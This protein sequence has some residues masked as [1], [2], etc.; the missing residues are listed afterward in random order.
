MTA[1]AISTRCACPTLM[2][3]GYLR[4]N[5][6]LEGKL[7]LSSAARMARSQSA[8][9]PEACARQASLNWVRIF[10]A[11]FRDD[12]GLCSTSA[13]FLPRRSRSSRSRRVNRS[14]PSKWIVPSVCARLPIEQA[15]NRHGQGALAR[16]ALA[17]QSEHFALANI[18]VH[19]AQ[20]GR[21]SAIAHGNAARREERRIGC[22]GS[23]L[24]ASVFLCFFK[25]VKSAQVRG[26]EVDSTSPKAAPTFQYVCGTRITGLAPCTARQPPTEHS[27]SPDK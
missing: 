23:S 11:G 18:E 7:T 5:S 8:C 12:S 16:S 22:R 17:H 1:I 13:I 24:I 6:S 25:S 2:C 26:K 10:R 27:D 20:H 21:L 14:Q 3:E 19:V 9:R 15:E 4:R